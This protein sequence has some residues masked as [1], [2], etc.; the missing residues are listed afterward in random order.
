[1]KFYRV[2]INRLTFDNLYKKIQIFPSS[3]YGY[4]FEHD[5]IH[6]IVDDKSIAMPQRIA[7]GQFCSGT[8]PLFFC[9]AQKKKKK[10][11]ILPI[12]KVVI[13]TNLGQRQE[14]A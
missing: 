7:L 5:T 10:K 8:A 6:N 12:F 1:M 13:I 4:K 14:S 9:L 3:A 11:N 2:V